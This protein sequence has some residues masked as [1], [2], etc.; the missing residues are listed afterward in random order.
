MPKKFPPEFKRDVADAARRREGES[1]EDIARTFGVS[2]SSVKR[3]IEQAD[4]DDGVADGLSSSEKAEL[5]QLRRDKRRLEMEVEILR[6]A[7]A[8]FAKDSA[9][10]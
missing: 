4:V 2:S 6:R 8:F 3:W 7:T 10:K 9:P 5:A 1:L